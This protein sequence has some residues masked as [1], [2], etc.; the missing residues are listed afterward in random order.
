MTSGEGGQSFVGLSFAAGWL[1]W[2]KTCCRLPF[3]PIAA[4]RVRGGNAP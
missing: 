1:G 3:R 2:Y 4:R